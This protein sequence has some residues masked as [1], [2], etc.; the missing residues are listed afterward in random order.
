MMPPH[1]LFNGLCYILDWSIPREQGWLLESATCIWA[2]STIVQPSSLPK[3][4]PVAKD[5]IRADQADLV[6]ASGLVPAA[7][8]LQGAGHEAGRPGILRRPPEPDR[9]GGARLRV[10]D[11]S[12]RRGLSV[13]RDRAPGGATGEGGGAGDAPVRRARR[14]RGRLAG[15]G[16][17]GGRRA[18]PGG[19]IHLF[20]LSAFVA[21]PGQTL[22]GALGEVARRPGQA[23]RPA[24]HPGRGRLPLPRHGARRGRLV[25]VADRRPELRGADDGAEPRPVHVCRRRAGPGHPA[26]GPGDV[27]AGFAP[28][29]RLCSAWPSS[30]RV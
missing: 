26:T 14:Q 2:L 21:A 9:P 19:V 20:P 27:C 11:A 16:R 6:A 25:R 28:D 17:R 30:W 7:R 4:T 22:L 10:Q 13:A 8:R 1:S 23:G 18:G 3:K 12:R 24:R 29:I 15:P 5:G